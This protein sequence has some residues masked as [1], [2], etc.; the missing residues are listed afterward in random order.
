[1]VGA[2]A[3]TIYDRQAKERKREGGKNAGRGRPQQVPDNCPEPNSGDSRDK[4]GAMF[5]VTG[6]ALDDC[7]KPKAK[8]RQRDHSGTAPGRK[9]TSGNLPEVKPKPEPQVRD[10]AAAA[11]G[12]SPHTYEK[13]KERR[14]GRPQKGRDNCPDL[15]EDGRTRD[16]IGAM[17]GV[18]G[19]SIDHLEA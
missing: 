16:K 17:F 4:L 13:A 10:V 2:R 6:K 12:M 1:M 14:K 7:E 5:G 3:R 9:N 11:V 19:K 15:N 8:A 18:S